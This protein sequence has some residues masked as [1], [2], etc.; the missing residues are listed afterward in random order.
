MS[1]LFAA[2]CG[3]TAL[4]YLDDTAERTGPLSAK[5]IEGRK[6]W[7]RKNCQVCH[8]TY[9]FGG[10]LGPD[11]TNAWPRL[12]R[13]RLDEVL[14]VG[15]AQMPAFHLTPAEIDG[16][17]AYLRELDKTGVGVARQ[18]T[19]VHPRLVLD[20]LE[21]HTADSETPAP[22]REGFAT[23]K[24]TCSACHIPFQATALGLNTAPDLSTVVDRLD[25]AAIHETI[26]NG[27]L[28]RGMPAWNL[29]EAK[30][31]E[32]VALLH[33][34]RTEHDV[35]TAKLPGVDRPQGLPWWEFK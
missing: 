15:N 16:I 27:R 10:F 33:W 28:A 2:F 32:L 29:P 34:L 7:H 30:V 20:A 14:T 4:V 12:S 9:G 18:K 26:Q 17:D 31:T 25:D 8:Q 11:L 13:A 24:A 19:P 5:A 22:V 23:F 21:A 35:L 1:G 6:T 3:Q